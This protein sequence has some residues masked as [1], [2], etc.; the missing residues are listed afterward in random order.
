MNLPRFLIIGAMKSGTTTLYRDLLPNPA[1]FMPLDKEPSNL[2]T[3][4]V[5]TG[6]GLE[7]YADLFASMRSD[8]IGGEASTSYTKIPTV[9]G[10]PARARRVLGADVRLIYVVREPVSRAISH[11]AHALTTGDTTER[12]INKDVRAK[13]KYLD[14]S[15]YAMQAE[16]WLDVFG[17]ERL[18]LVRFETFVKDRK[19]TIEQISR[20][21]GVP[22]RPDLVKEDEVYN[23][24]SERVRSV[25][26]GGAIAESAAYKKLL[27]PIFS[28][29]MRTRVRSMILPRADVKPIAPTAETIDWMLERLGPDTE[30]LS[31]L[32]GAGGPVWDV[33]AVRAKFVEGMAPGSALSQ[34]RERA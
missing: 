30:R 26:I 15:R 2:N 18:M 31:G 12:D 16:A 34:G 32:M 20:F 11:H 27:R 33:A 25:G 9:S 7:R 10:V 5:L 6:P 21:I 23:R 24:T 8:Q 3:D 29:E 28:V 19:G 14:Y 4:E 1:V 22:A 13:G 17:P